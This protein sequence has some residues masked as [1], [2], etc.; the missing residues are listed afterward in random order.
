MKSPTAKQVAFVLLVAL[1]LRL[2]AAWAWQA[3]L[4]APFRFGDSFSYWHLGRAL[5][6]GE[7]YRYGEYGF[8]FRTP[9]YPVL[10]A[11]I[12]WVAGPDASPLWG[13]VLGAVFGTLSVFGVWWLAQRLFDPRAGILA[14]VIAAVY[15]GAIVTSVL[16]LSE[17][18]FCPLMLAHLALWTAAWQ[19]A[20]PSRNSLFAFLGG[21]MAG[22]ATLVRPSWLLFTPLAI[23]VGLIASGQRRRSL[24]VGAVMLLGLVTAMLPWWI[25][26]ARLTGHFVATS[27]QVGASLYD[28]WSP[29]ATG[30]SNMEF[31]GRFVDLERRASADL[32]EDD[33]AAFEYRLDR[34]M[35]TA[36]VQWALQHPGRA[37][38]LAV[39]K[40]LRMWNVW[41]NEQALSS[42][43]VRV[44]ILGSYLP[45]LVLAIVGAARTVRRGLPYVF[46][47]LPAVY[48][49]LL[50]V[51]FV[52]SIRYRQPAMLG[53]I[54]LA[55][56]VVSE[57]V[58][59]S[60]SMRKTEV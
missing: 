50:H 12:F 23:L 31:V 24:A 54:V 7:P 4:D 18:P 15:P 2:V 45:V 19:A 48:F 43:P 38:E 22:A 58:W 16:V 11:P 26:N 33:P 39:I 13:R 29:D 20:T 52:S 44:I 9:G 41:P 17:A 34:R 3:R 40:F 6:A 21:L 60:R 53:L 14:A 59:R 49:T 51:V 36:A 1:V 32:P 28:G 56:G 42:W 57:E 8:V 46:C 25:R 5:A 37:A 30:A 47:W 55:A 27:L 10:L 35:R